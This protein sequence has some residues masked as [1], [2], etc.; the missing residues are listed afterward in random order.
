MDAILGEVTLTRRRKKLDEM[1]KGKGLGV[2][3]A[4]TL[5][6]MQAQPGSRSKLGLDVLLWRMQSSH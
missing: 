4:E 1:T 3:Y 5:S 6:R 2:A